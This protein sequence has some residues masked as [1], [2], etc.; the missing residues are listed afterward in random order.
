[1]KIAII[2]SGISGLT[3][4]WHLHDKHDIQLF[5]AE[6]RLGGHTAT[7]DVTTPSGQYA[8]DTGF[9]VFNDR[10]YPNFERFL[11]DIGLEG[12]KTQM[13]FSVRNDEENLEYNG[14]TLSTLFA[15]RSNFLRPRFYGL[16]REILRFNTLA[17]NAVDEESQLRGTLGDFLDNNR[18]N[19]FFVE[20][21]ILPM[22]AAIWSST[23]SDMRSF[24]LSFFLRFFLNHGLLDIKN[25][26]QWYVIP[27]GSREYIRKIEPM[28]SPFVNLN[29]P[30]KEVRRS[31]EGVEVVTPSGIQFFDQVIFA[32]HSDQALAML[33]DP[34][35]AELEVLGAIPYQ[36]NEVVLHTDTSMLPTREKAWA[37]WN[38]RLNKETVVGENQAKPTTLT[39]NMN[40]LQG[41]D[42]PETFCVTLN[43]TDQI[44]PQAIVEQFEYAHPVFNVQSVAAQQ[45]R[46]EVNGLHR[47]WF[48]GAY[49]YN[50]FHED[51]VR[52]ALDVVEGIGQLNAFSESPLLR[53]SA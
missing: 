39:Y 37:S 51:G 40:I 53:T 1:M 7:V 34:T 3:C 10:T 12:Q 49:W 17:K 22:G 13:S 24:P 20:N 31:S 21:Y 2:G 35:A 5:E 6:S 14:H 50:G 36:K 28:L 25:R 4:A 18:F 23:L 33:A 32:C 27:G 19:D 38:Y 29:C 11:A 52:S 48:C 42:A 26:P 45:R 41:I 44:N 8:I 9:I 47:S 30:V 43:Q 46:H 16:I 15:Q